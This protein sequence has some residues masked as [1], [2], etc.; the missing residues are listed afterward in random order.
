MEDGGGRGSAGA[1]WESRIFGNENMVMKPMASGT[2]NQAISEMTLAYFEDTGLY[3]VDYS[4]ATGLFPQ[5][6]RLFMWG[7]GA[8]APKG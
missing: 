2:G 1:H 5:E 6:H 3:D 7:R 8:M 4:A